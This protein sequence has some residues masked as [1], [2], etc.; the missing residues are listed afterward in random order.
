[1][2]LP[3]GR[4]VKGP[5]GD[6]AKVV[7]VLGPKGRAGRLLRGVLADASIRATEQLADAE[8]RARAILAEA[9][10]VAR[11]VRERAHEE[12]QKAGAAELAT[13]WAKLR[14][15]EAERDERDLDR[16]IELARAMAE[17]LIGET[18]ALEPAKVV[19]IARQTLASARQARR[20]VLSAHPDD[21]EALRQNIASLGLE[22]TAIEIHADPARTR[23]S[24][25][26]DTDLGTLDAK[27]SIQLDRL[28]RS[29]RDSFRSS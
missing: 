15:E 7:D 17:R 13:A 18:L 16:T 6:A 5:S 14:A 22:K 29:L 2:T 24:L 12:G 8:T 28:A 9:E 1:M 4:I 10:Q 26:L 3:K 23:G 19:S 25:L 20:I 27:L 11:S 21:A